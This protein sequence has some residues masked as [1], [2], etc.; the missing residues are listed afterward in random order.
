LT[1]SQTS[2]KI[3][4]S[5]IVVAIFCAISFLI[6]TGYYEL[7]AT[8]VSLL[9]F[10]LYIYTLKLFNEK[11]SDVESKLWM[12]PLAYS[13]MLLILSLSYSFPVQYLKAVEANIGT[14]EAFYYCLITLTTV[15]YGE[16]HPA[17]Y[18]GQILSASMA[19][20]GTAHM[21]MFISILVG[22]LKKNG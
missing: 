4:V 13:L 18:T 7:Y 1:I 2:K 14:F 9:I 19:L 22:N 3:L 11:F 8:F 16:L 12:V 5:W 10:S 17:G 15:G 20:V 6:P 21:I